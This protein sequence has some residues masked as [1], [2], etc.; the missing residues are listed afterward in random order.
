MRSALSLKSKQQGVLVKKVCLNPFNDSF[1]TDDVAFSTK[2]ALILMIALDTGAPINR[3]AFAM[4]GYVNRV[5]IVRT[6]ANKHTSWS[7]CMSL[8]TFRVHYV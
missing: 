4:A 5:Y 3:L 2:V 7:A 6:H 8:N 1:A